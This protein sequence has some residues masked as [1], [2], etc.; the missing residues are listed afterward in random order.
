MGCADARARS[1]ASPIV[2]FAAALI[3]MLLA[4]DLSGIN[5]GEVIRL[6]IFLACLFQVP[7]AYVCVR[8]QTRVAFLIVLMLTIVQSALG[9][10]TIGFAVP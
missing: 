2:L 10:A 4:L 7:A 1:L 6:W 8:L 3:V 5:R 9:T